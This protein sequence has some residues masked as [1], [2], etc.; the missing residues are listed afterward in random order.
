VCIP[1]GLS[2]TRNDLNGEN[3]MKKLAVIFL[4]LSMVA[5]NAF[6]TVNVNTA[7]QEQLESLNG[8]G[9][10][11]AKAIIDYRNKNGNFKSVEE[12]DKVPG[13]GQGILAKI[14]GDASVSGSTTV[15]AES[16]KTDSP[17][18]TSKPEN[19]TADKAQNKSDKIPAAETTKADKKSEAKA[20]KEEKAAKM[21]EDK[22]TKA[23]KKS[24]NKKPEADT[25]K[26]TDS[27]S[28]KKGKKG[29]P[30]SDK[31]SDASDTKK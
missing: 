18:K 2:E 26:K 8:I 29:D 25:D 5:F 13:I 12:L 4:A 11:K 1:T 19:K 17:A 16:K 22:A 31:K 7:T 27:K 10:A 14:K 30:T 24:K 9:P 20:A 3:H 28:S 6:A 23:E 21:K 15:K